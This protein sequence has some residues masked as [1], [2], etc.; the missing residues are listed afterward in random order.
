MGPGL[1]EPTQWLHSALAPGSR[2]SPLLSGHHPSL[3]VGTLPSQATLSATVQSPSP[4][5]AGA[6]WR[7]GRPVSNTWGPPGRKSHL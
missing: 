3:G 6:E 2:S 1:T 4:T 5:L 7:E